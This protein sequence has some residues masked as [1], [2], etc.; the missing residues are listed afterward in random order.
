MHIVHLETGRHLYGGAQQ[1]LYLLEG[2][3]REGVRS[4]LVCPPDS[5]IGTAAGAAGVN[6]QAMP[7]A[8]DLDA[9]FGR[10]FARWLKTANAQLLHVH[11]RRG[12]D[13]WGGLAARYAGVSAVLSR[14][15]DSTDP[16]IIG[17][18]KYRPYARVI[19]ISAQ[20]R[21]QLQATGVPTE[22]L[23]VVHS[24]VNAEAFKP[25]W[26]RT[27]FCAAFGLPVGAL[28][29]V[30]VAQLIARKGHACLLEAWLSIVTTC[31]RARLVLFGQGP[32][33]T[34]LRQQVARLG[35]Q[36]SVVFA[37]FRQDLPHFL[38][39]ADLLVHPALREGLG[40]CLLEAQAAELPIVATQVGGIPEAVADGESGLLVPPAD[41]CALAA[42]VITL[43]QDAGKRSNFGTAGRAYVMRE[44]SL[45]G[46]VSGNVQV[47][48][49]IL[50]ERGRIRA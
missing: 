39:C 10:R 12:A 5:A 37:G 43:L 26:S 15:V 40:V 35:L 19:C 33:E 4:T 6:V 29:V 31:P 9:L 36:E 50:Q 17:K 23:R 13:V 22:K 49:E 18:F 28:A 16:P 30:C 25:R 20:I 11:S 1:V 44:F 48:R 45:A 7:M 2:L 3:A 46:M 42:S 27:D 21:R 24:T 47:Y 14:R 32:E 8:G 41:A 38:G 34:S